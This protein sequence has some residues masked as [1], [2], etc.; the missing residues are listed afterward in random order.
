MT[1]LDE[2]IERERKHT[3]QGNKRGEW[4]EYSVT[5]HPRC[6]RV[7][8]YETYSYRED[9]IGGGLVELVKRGSVELPCWASCSVLKRVMRT[10]RTAL[11]VLKLVFMM[12]AQSVTTSQCFTKS[13]V[14]TDLTISRPL[15]KLELVDCESPATLSKSSHSM[16]RLGLSSLE[17]DVIALI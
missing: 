8:R 1:N 12:E 16:L 5:P 2:P 9:I 13:L 15:E 4:K 6:S 3:E 14:F 17:N 11:E 10:W 7:K